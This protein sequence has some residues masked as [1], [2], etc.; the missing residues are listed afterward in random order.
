VSILPHSGD[1]LKA[2]FDFTIPGSHPTDTVSLTS[3]RVTLPVQ[4]PDGSSTTLIVPIPNQSITVPANNSQWF[5]SG[6]QSSPLVY[7]GSITVPT[8]CGG[9]TGHAPQGATFSTSLTATTT[10]SVHVRFHFGDNTSGSWSST[11]GYCH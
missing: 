4:C 2:G 3:S 7:Q 10:N 5:P 8:I 11:Q 1:T 6:N 9:A